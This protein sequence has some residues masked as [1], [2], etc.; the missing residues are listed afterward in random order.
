MQ[1]FGFVVGV[2][3]KTHQ[4]NIGDAFQQQP[5]CHQGAAGNIRG[6]HVRR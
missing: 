2:A 6:Q 1:D 4:L 5:Q 3:P